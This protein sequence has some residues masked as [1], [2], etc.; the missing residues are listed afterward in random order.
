V[1]EENKRLNIRFEWDK[2]TESLKEVDA[3]MKS[4]LWAATVSRAY[5]GVFYLARALVFSM[6]LEARSHGGLVHL[7]S[8][9]LV[10]AGKFPA[11]LVRI[12]SRMQRQRE[13]ADYQTALTFDESTAIEARESFIKFRTAVEEYLVKEGFFP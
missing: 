6:G 3:L 13:D 9:N 11:D 5:Y 1:T 7:L 12:F 2:S 4:G 10:R 8:A